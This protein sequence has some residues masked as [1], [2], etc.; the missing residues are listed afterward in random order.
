MTRSKIQMI[1]FFV[2][3]LIFL[4]AQSTVCDGR[5]RINRDV[6]K[7]TLIE[8][9]VYSIAKN[10]NTHTPSNGQKNEH[11]NA[12]SLGDTTTNLENNKT[13]NGITSKSSTDNKTVNAT[14][15]Q[16]E[17]E[18]IGHLTTLNAGALKRGLY[19]FIGL[20]V[21]V[22]AYIMFRNF[23]LSKTRAQMVRKYGVL[24]NRQDVEMRPLPLDEEDDED[25]TVF[26]ASNIHS[27]NIQHQNL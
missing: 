17:H 7:P 13:L 4:A 8:K 2:F 14:E 12:V 11:Q 19:V 20:S 25:T 26:D 16:K 3:L 21:L 6:P 23:R 10:V 24:A 9:S 22:M 1:K 27:N 18:E 5:V 15:P